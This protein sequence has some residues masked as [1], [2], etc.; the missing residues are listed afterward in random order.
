MSVFYID[1]DNFLTAKSVYSDSSLLTKAPDG[2]YSYSGN[3]RRQL[4]GKLQDVAECPISS[5]PVTFLT[6]ED[7]DVDVMLLGDNI[8]NVNYVITSL[9]N[10]LEGDIYDKVTSLKI[11]S[12][13]YTLASFGKTIT[14]K[15]FSNFYGNVNPFNFKLNL[16]N[17][18]SN[19][20]TVSG[21][22]IA[23]A[24]AP[25]F[26]QLAPNFDGAPGD[27]YTYTGTVSDPDA[28]SDILVVSVASNSSLPPGWTFVQTPGTNTFT[29]SG[30][31]PPGADYSIILQVNDLDNP[32]NASQQVVSV[33]SIFTT[34]AS[35]EFKLN[36]FDTLF[37][38]GGTGSSPKTTSPIVLSNTPSGY[39]T[40]H[41]CNRAQFNLVAG[42][43]AN[44]NG[45]EWIW[46]NLGKGSLNNAGANNQTYNV[47]D[48]NID[49]LALIPFISNGYVIPTSYLNVAGGLQ[50]DLLNYP[51]KTF[52]D[53]DPQTYYNSSN[54]VANSSNRVSYFDIS[55][56]EATELSNS[57]NWIGSPNRGV[58]KF[59]L[60]P[61]S[62]NSNG[63]A[64]YHSDSSWMQVFKQNLA[65]TNQ[66]E[67][68]NPSTNQSFLLTS[69]VVITVDIINNT[70]T[71]GAS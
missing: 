10:T 29:I 5:Y 50:T 61:N 56:L 22:V 18:D 43:F 35:M 12:V 49:E 9:P 71:V 20:S 65:G 53:G 21:I 33:N 46:K 69:S 14:F 41:T 28:P 30:P 66:E 11:S 27:T 52:V 23:V 3:Y 39:G 34:L 6:N 32:S 68:L 38:S 25:I 17:V 31:V 70:V 42:V 44:S 36:Y 4:F 16:G 7:T 64:N 1:T 26:D 2:Y 62:Y 40:G 51:L 37:P 63:A 55:Q 8:P 67:V 57:S 47:F 58:V 24:D 60:V 15:P 59:K 45:G 19:I 48:N 13:P 54:F